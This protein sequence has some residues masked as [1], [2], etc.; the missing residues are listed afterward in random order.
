MGQRSAFP[1]AR[2]TDRK[3]G[4]NELLKL[5]FGC[6]VQGMKSRYDKD[7]WHWKSK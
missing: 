2:P 5:D 4:S 7:D 3:I 1:H 6:T